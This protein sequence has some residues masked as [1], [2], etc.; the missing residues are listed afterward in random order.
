MSESH[1]AMF[2]VRF[3]LSKLE[4]VNGLLRHSRL[5][6]FGITWWI[7]EVAALCGGGGAWLGHPQLGDVV[8]IAHC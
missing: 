6:S 8:P 1:A 7:W 3:Q 2:G 4:G 5:V